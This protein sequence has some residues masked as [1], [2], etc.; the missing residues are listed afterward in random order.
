M[1]IQSKL[2]TIL[3]G[4]LLSCMNSQQLL[5]GVNSISHE[6]GLNLLFVETYFFSCIY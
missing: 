1:Y 3:G 6:I 5:T 4:Y 2:K